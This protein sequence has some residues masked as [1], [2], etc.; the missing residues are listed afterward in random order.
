MCQ[1]YSRVS[2]NHT[3]RVK[4]QSVCGNRTL[5]VEINL[6]RVEITLVRVGI[7]FVRFGITFVPVEITIHVES[8]LCVLESHWSV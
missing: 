3:L 2:G 8:T 1:N 6:V 5:R 4:S 7:T